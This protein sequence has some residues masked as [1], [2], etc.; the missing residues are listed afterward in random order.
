MK[1][2]QI[3]TL[4]ATSIQP[5]WIRISEACRLSS[6]TKPVMYQ[7]MQRGLVKNFSNRQRGQIKGAR[8]VNLESLRSFLESRATGGKAQ[9]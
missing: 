5:E 3:N 1:D 4:P 2:S 6:V 9:A 7:W 8:L